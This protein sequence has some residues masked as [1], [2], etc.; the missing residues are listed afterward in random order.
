[1]IVA[2]PSQPAP[3]VRRVV[4]LFNGKL[5]RASAWLFVG[6][7]A[8]GVLGYVFQILMG[9]MLS[10][11][12]Y[13]LYSAVMALFAVLGAPT[14]TL[15]MVVSRKVSEYK[16]R[17][18]QGSLYHFF[19][20]INVRTAM[21]VGLAVLACGL[22]VS[23]IQNYLKAPTSLP[24]YLLGLLLFVNFFPLINNAFL[25]GLQSFT[26]LSFSS[27][28]GVFTKILVAA[29]F[30]HL[31][32]GVNGA[33]G[34]TVVSFAVGWALTFTALRP[35]L[36]Q[37]KERSFQ[38]SHLSF[39]PVLPV[40][41]ANVAFAAMTQLDLLLVNY[42]FSPHEAS[43]YAAA[44][45]LGKAVMYLPGGITLALF[46]MV[47]ENEAHGRGSAHL[48]KQ[49]IGLTLLLCGTGA[50]FYY[51]F[52]EIIISILYGQSYQGAGEILKYYGFAI[53]PMAL[54]MIAEHFLIAKGR[55]LFA[56]LFVFIAP[57]QLITI[58]YFHS[59]PMIVVGVMGLSG[60]VLAL[61]GYGLLW[62]ASRPPLALG[63]RIG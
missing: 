28:F 45:I 9:R 7:L 23:Q 51:L 52:G 59:S 54:V 26:W 4:G 12:E 20:S 17:Q 48:L 22:G 2:E 5:A 43:L 30:V 31:G 40:L 41:V 11:Q 29:L 10:T 13:G 53:L 27:S 60:A 63:A 62:R 25:Q 42:Y 18:D 19:A 37:G 21:V 44:A 36:L 46:P 24:V 33:L 56:Y 38:T 34:G 16:A 49:A 32:F 47:A 61:I 8:G 50:V 3:L 57:L 39:K 14:G 58:Y 1:M 35:V 6:S 15:M 55:V